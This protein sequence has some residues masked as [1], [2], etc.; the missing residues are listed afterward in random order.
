MKIH[1]TVIISTVSLFA[2]LVVSLVVYDQK[3]KSNFNHIVMGESQAEVKHALGEPHGVVE[4]GTFG[5]SPPPGCDEEFSYVSALTF[6]DVWTVSFDTG[7]H[8]VRKLRYR[9]P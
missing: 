5:G 1:K 3:L 9:S 8:V 7:G 4:C 2:A 6:W